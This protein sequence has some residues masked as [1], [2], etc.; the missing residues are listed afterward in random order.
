LNRLKIVANGSAVQAIMDS[1]LQLF[2]AV[3]YEA[4]SIA[5]GDNDW[6]EVDRPAL[7]QLRPSEAGWELVVTD[8]MHDPQNEQLVVKTSINL[9]P[10]RYS[11]TLPGVHPRAG[12]SAVVSRKDEVTTVVVELPDHRDDKRLG[13][14]GALY[15]GAPLHLRIPKF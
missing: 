3:F 1:S 4:G 6:I 13:Y 5:F 14:Q 2:Q 11:Y 9:K 15:N 8:P 7:V 10:G 12:E